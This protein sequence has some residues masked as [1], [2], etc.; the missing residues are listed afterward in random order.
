MLTVVPCNIDFVCPICTLIF[1]HTV[2]F[3]DLTACICTLNAQLISTK[4]AAEFT[5]ADTTNP[6][7][8]LLFCVPGRNLRSNNLRCC[9]VGEIITLILCLVRHL[10]YNFELI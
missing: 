9:F 2:G 7:I 8:V 3:Q 5:D 6:V 10:G 4:I 1:E